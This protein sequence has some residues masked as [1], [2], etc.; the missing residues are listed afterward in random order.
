MVCLRL[1]YSCLLM[2]RFVSHPVLYCVFLVTGALAVSGYVCRIAGFSWYLAVFCLVY[3]GGVYI[4]F[5]FV[6]VYRPNSSPFVG[7][8]GFWFVFFFL[9]LLG[10]FRFG[11]GDLWRVSERRHYLCTYFEGF[12]Y[13]LFCLVLMLGFIGVRVVVSEKDSFFR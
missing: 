13:C 1:Y 9:M 5:I 7:G 2:F 11:H 6:S 4:L 10:L 8:S 12:S 3:V